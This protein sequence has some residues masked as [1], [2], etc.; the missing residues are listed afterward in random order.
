MR[1]LSLRWLLL[2]MVLMVL[3][4]PLAGLL[5]LR[6]YESALIRQTES[7]LF[8]QAAVIASAYKAERLR[9]GSGEFVRAATVPERFE[10]ARRPGL[11]LAIDPVLPPAPDPVAAEAA[12]TL[13][14]EAGAVLTPVLK[15]AQEVTLAAIRIVD[16][17]GVV[18]ATTGADLGRS[19]ANQDE[20]G[21]A[22]LGQPTSVMRQREQQASWVSGG[23]SRGSMLRVDVALPVL[24]G[25]RVLGAVLAVRTPA[26]I[27]Q[28]LAGK[29]WQLAWLAA[30]LLAIGTVLALAMSRLVTRPLSLVTAQAATVAA[31]STKAVRPLRRPGTREVAQL[32]AAIVAMAETLD[33][34]ATY[35][36]TLAARIAHEFK[37]PLTA[38]RGAAELLRDHAMSE[39]E[40]L[41]FLDVIEA[42]VGRLDRLTRRLLELARADMTAGPG[43]GPT[44]VLPVLEAVAA[45]F[46]HRGLCIQIE[47]S[48]AKAAVDK[49]PLDAIVA[50]LL[51]NVVAHGGT[52]VEIGVT[53]H[54]A[55][56]LIWVA[57]DGPGISPANAPKI[58]DAFFTTAREHGGTGLGLPIIQAFVAGVGGS[59]RFVPGRPG[60]AFEVRLPAQR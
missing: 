35:V 44:L 30:V 6:M 23:I 12:S 59:I 3:A 53:T 2:A 48:A 50:G 20:V 52:N 21:R 49:E 55:E 51:D 16:P 54:G 9:H 25:D 26:D 10:V 43:R 39:S 4:L 34:R 38:T 42:E 56:I 28:A 37:T 14:Q 36:R 57:D 47:A 11:D 7:E 33:K 13:A 29:R 18:V 40:R 60:A 22:L 45:R 31:G 24:D 41:H 32:S 15:E 46:I 1:R 19:I 58:F 5:F 27:M 8:A 17:R